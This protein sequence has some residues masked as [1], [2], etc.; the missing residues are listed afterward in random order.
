MKTLAQAPRDKPRLTSRLVVC[1]DDGGQTPFPQPAI[2]LMGVV[3]RADQ[4]T[5]RPCPVIGPTTTASDLLAEGA[6]AADDGA[7]AFIEVSRAACAAAGG[8]MAVTDGGGGGGLGGPTVLSVSAE[9][10]SLVTQDTKLHVLVSAIYLPTVL[11]APVKVT[12]VAT[13]GG[14]GRMLVGGA[15]VLTGLSFQ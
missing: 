3:W 1:E 13:N 8:T 15:L 14:G 7:V 11:G 12:A 10:P 6:T 2:R 9:N 5:R 4:A